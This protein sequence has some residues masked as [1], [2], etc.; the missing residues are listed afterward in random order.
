[1]ISVEANQVCAV[2]TAANVIEA[3]RLI[4]TESFDVLITDPLISKCPV[5]ATAL[6]QSPRCAIS[7]RRH[8]LCWSGAASLAKRFPRFSG[9]ASGVSMF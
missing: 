2:V 5:P 4:T 6:L 9:E 7:I 3:L 1:M 8:L